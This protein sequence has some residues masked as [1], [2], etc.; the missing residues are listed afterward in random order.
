[1]GSGRVSRVGQEQPV[2]AGGLVAI[3]PPVYLLL[4]LA[5]MVLVHWFLPGGTALG[6]PWR[7]LGT[8]PLVLGIALNLAADQ[9]LKRRATA[10]KPLD[11]SAALVT[12]G[13]FRLSRHPMY[14]GFVL[15]L[16]GVA[17]LLGSVT[18]HALVLG[19]GLFLDR[20]FVRFEEG[21]LE[22][23]FGQAWRDYTTQVR[24]W[25]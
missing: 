9:A 23:T 13:A 21:K 2:K 3:D 17:L 14:L 10:V 1:M 6:Y 8:V 22:A 25:L 18:P 19:S 12:D 15:I 24:R 4:C 5:L 20:V 7:A 16:L 11:H